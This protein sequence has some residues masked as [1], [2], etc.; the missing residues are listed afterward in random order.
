VEAFRACLAAQPEPRLAADCRFQVGTAL[1]QKGDAD[2]AIGELRSFLTEYKTERATP[3]ALLALADLYLGK[4]D[5]AQAEAALKAAPADGDEAYGARRALLLGTVLR[6]TDRAAE[7]I[8][9]LQTAV[10]RGSG[11]SIGR[12]QFELAAALSATGKHAEAAEAFLNVAILHAES[13]YAPQALYEAGHA[14]EAAARPDEAKKAYE[15][16][17]K[18]YP[19]ATEW[20]DKAKARLAALGG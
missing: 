2:A 14:F 18:D 4:Q 16:L 11:S 12:A 13:P 1:A 3:F 10:A 5:W 15:S 17:A 9:L 20:V 7:A 6:R 19:A 8:P